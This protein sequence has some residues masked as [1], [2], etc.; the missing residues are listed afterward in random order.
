M[1]NKDLL[2]KLNKN[3]RLTQTRIDILD[4]LNDDIHAH[5]IKDIVEHLN[6]KGK[7]VNVASVYNTIKI[8]INEGIVDI[9]TNYEN[10]T[11]VFEIVN[12]D[13]FHIHVYDTNHEKEFKINMPKTIEDEIRSILDKNDL[14][15]HNIKIEILASSKKK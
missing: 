10:K 1:N 15:V 14:S 11:Q 4:C 7:K 8:L 6:S 12:K 5:T 2:K 13:K 3:Y 9:Y